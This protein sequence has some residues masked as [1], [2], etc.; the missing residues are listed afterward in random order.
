[1]ATR[2][3]FLGEAGEVYTVEFHHAITEVL[4]DT[5]H[6]T[7]ATAVDLDACLVALVADVG[8]SICMDLS[9]F[10][11]DA[12][13][14][15]LH[16][17]FGDVAVGP[18]MIY[19]LLHEFGVSELGGEVSIVGEQEHAGGVAVKTTHGIDSLFASILDNVEHGGASVGI[20]ACGDTVFGLI[21]E[22]VAFA[23]GSYDL[24]VIFH[25]VATADLGAEFGHYF[26]IY[27][28][29][30]AGDIFI[31]FA[32]R[33]DAGVGHKLI[34]A[35][36]FI[37]IDVVEYVV[38][39]FGTWREF[40]SLIVFPV[41]LAGAIEVTLL[42]ALLTALIVEAATL[43]AM[44]EA[45][46]LGTLLIATL[47]TLLVATLLALLIATLLTLLLAT[48]LT[49]LVTTLLTRLVTTLHRLLFIS[50]V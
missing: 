40:G 32:T 34:E 35:N 11:F 5:T 10:E 38:D 1:M 22:D 31:S 37:R 17:L 20:V 30:A 44:L 12:I 21:E 14:D 28:H 26:S 13:G 48:L 41:L 19:F 49:G 16:I 46:L 8:D 2:Q 33:A 9:I 45:T 43:L 27:L 7:V 47:L 4:E 36:F 24:A 18:D 3:I 15:A 6:D 23:F 42:G 29:Q 39:L 50:H 25:D